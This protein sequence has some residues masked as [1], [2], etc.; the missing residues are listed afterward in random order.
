MKKVKFYGELDPQN[1]WPY[2]FQ[3]NF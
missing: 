1:Y 3:T 2:E